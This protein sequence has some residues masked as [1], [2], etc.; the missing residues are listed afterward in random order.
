M[1]DAVDQYVAIFNPEYSAPITLPDPVGVRLTSQCCDAGMQR[2]WC[3]GYSLQSIQE[4]PRVRPWQGSELLEN[5]GRDNQRHSF[6]LRSL[7]ELYK[8]KFTDRVRP[9]LTA[10][11]SLRP[12]Y[13]P[14]LTNLTNRSASAISAATAAR[15]CAASVSSPH[16]SA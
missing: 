5:A 3:K 4:S 16:C 1:W 6:N 13:Y 9:S 11:S 7:R 15:R 12:I 2:R 8:M 14:C 10:P